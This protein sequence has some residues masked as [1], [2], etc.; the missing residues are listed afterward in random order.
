MHLSSLLMTLKTLTFLK[1]SLKRHWPS[2]FSVHEVTLFVFNLNFNPIRLSKKEFYVYP[3]MTQCLIIVERGERRRKEVRNTTHF[4]F[5]YSTAGSTA[6]HAA[7]VK[8]EGFWGVDPVTGHTASLK[9]CHD[10]SNAPKCPIS[11]CH[12]LRVGSKNRGYLKHC[13]GHY[14][15]SDRKQFM[16]FR[17]NCCCSTCFC[18]KPNKPDAKSG[19][20]SGKEVSSL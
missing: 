9:A 18:E 7:N 20:Q 3:K 5:R 15:P 1:G 12:M 19:V 16:A 10:A 13:K 17:D 2:P 6:G 14:C 8:L 11:G 4:R